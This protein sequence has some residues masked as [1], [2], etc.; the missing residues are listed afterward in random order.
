MSHA[1]QIRPAVEADVPLILRYI[2]ELAVYEKLRH[3]VAATETA[4]REHLFCDKPY[5]EVLLAEYQGDPAG[6]ALYFH[7]FSTFLAK[8]GVY[9]E[10]LYV[11]EHYRGKGIGKA[12]L[13]R[14]AQI[15]KERRCGRL[16]WWVL[17]WNEPAI[18]FYKSIGAEPMSDWTVFRLTG[19]ALENLA[20]S[21]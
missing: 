6:F 9:L 5:A 20:R 11:P 15:A 17:D 19:E 2:E 4:L 3:E 18:R 10:D 16:E 12:L 21:S 13:V 1:L 8:P 7:N 14:L